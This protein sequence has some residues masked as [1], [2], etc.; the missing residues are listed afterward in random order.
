[1]ILSGLIVVDARFNGNASGN[2]FVTCIRDYAEQLFDTL[3]ADRRDDP[4]LGQVSADGI[5]YR[6]LLADEQMTGAMQRQTTLLLWRFGRHESHVRSG[7]RFT[8]RFGVSGII[9]MPL[10]IG[11]NVGRRHQADSV[12][13]RL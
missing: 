6:G 5:D 3:A 13:K 10:N 9:L 8:D 7:N 4:K 1:M 2:R 11:L 12:A